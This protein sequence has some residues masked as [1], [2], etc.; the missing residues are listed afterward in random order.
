MNNSNLNHQMIFEIFGIE[1]LQTTWLYTSTRLFLTLRRTLHILNI[2]PPAD[3]IKYKAGDIFLIVNECHEDQNQQW[4]DAT[5][6]F[7]HVYQSLFLFNRPPFT[8]KT[9]K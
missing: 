6:K 3:L 1:W 7:L 8:S 2:H 4:I 9:I 5:N